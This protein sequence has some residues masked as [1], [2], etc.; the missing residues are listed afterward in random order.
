MLKRILGT[1]VVAGGVIAA[2]S[3]C[4]VTQI[5]WA[6]HFYIVSSACAPAPLT[7]G[8]TTLHNGAGFIGTPGTLAAPASCSAR[9]STADLTHDGIQDAAVFLNCHD[10]IGGNHNGS[11][12]QIFTRNSQPVQRLVAPNRQ[13]PG[14]IFSP[15]F[16]D[17]EIEIVK[18]T[19]YTGVESFLPA[20][21]HAGPSVH[22]TY[23]WDWNG[24]S[25]TPVLVQSAVK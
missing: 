12:I 3:G 6:N 8:A 19:L 7:A 1:A 18:N 5:S 24:H 22:E 2:L 20:D 25:F 4:E 9:S 11:E 10:T 21:P 17:N 23:R 13:L 16:I 14:T 15:Y